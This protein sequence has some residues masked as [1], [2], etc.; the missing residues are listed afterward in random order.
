[1]KK[2]MVIISVFLLA[3]SLYGCGGGPSGDGSSGTIS[4]PTG[5]PKIELVGSIY[6]VEDTL[7]DLRLFGKVENKGNATATFVEAKF[8]FYD[9][10]SNLIGT[11][12]SF[13]NGTVVRLLSINTNTNTALKPSERGFFQIWT[14]LKKIAVAK[15]TYD[16]TYS[17][18]QIADPAAKLEIIGTVNPQRDSFDYLDLLGQVKN[19]GTKGLIFGEVIFMIKDASGSIIDV[20][21]SYITGETVQ[22]S[23]INTTTDTA[24]SINGQGTF[25]VSTLVPFAN[26]GSYESKYDWNDT[27]IQG[28]I[29]REFNELSRQVDALNKRDRLSMSN[30]RTERLRNLSAQ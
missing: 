20:D 9:S 3:F 10:A 5:Q 11:D 29:S 30:Q 1:M 24:L 7:G 8:N 25:D 6:A 21:S 14:S 23:S 28:G 18:S 22:I 2:W 17:T 12:N 26:Y 15:Y 4:G 19:V 16:F 27:D 13:I